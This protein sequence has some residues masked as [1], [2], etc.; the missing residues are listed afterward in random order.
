[1][2]T[3]IDPQRYEELV[4]LCREGREQAARGERSGA[5]ASFLEAW[6]ILLEPKEAWDAST[7]I[8]AA[9]GDLLRAGGDLSNALDVL[10]H[11]R[12]RT[13]GD[14]PPESRH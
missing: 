5:L 7:W 9:V 3:P 1:V 12:G 8:L 14:A 10:V 4:R 13:A 6:D 2:A 11:A